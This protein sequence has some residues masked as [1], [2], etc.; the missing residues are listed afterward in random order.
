M[1]AANAGEL[2]IDGRGVAFICLEHFTGASIPRPT[3]WDWGPNSCRSGSGTSWRTPFATRRREPQRHR[4]DRARIAW[5]LRLLGGG[6][7][8]DAAE[9]L[10]NEGLA[11]HAPRRWPR[12]SGTDYFGLS[13]AGS[14]CGSRAGGLPPS[15]GGHP[16]WT[17]PDSGL[18]SVSLGGNGARP[19][20]SWRAGRAENG[21]L[22]MGYRL[23]EALVADVASRRRCW[24]G[25]S[26]RATRR[27]GRGGVRTAYG[28][29]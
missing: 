24:Q 7:P 21:P 9:L 15:R 10:V 27:K 16:T 1:G 25:R 17:A 11:V 19:H 12:L 13:P 5:L 3:G 26:R 23:T 6:E 8:G 2:V 22:Y 20:G 29:G 14:T 18:R 4:P 28:E